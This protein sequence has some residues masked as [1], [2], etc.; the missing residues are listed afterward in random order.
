MILISSGYRFCFMEF[1]G[2]GWKL[3]QSCTC[4]DGLKR[5]K[6]QQSFLTIWRSECLERWLELAY[7]D[8]WQSILDT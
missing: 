1:A 7:V 6:K 5:G 2:E 4:L 8:M 3:P